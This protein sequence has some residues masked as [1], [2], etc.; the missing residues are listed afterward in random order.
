MVLLNFVLVWKNKKIEKK[1]IVLGKKIMNL[2][3]AENKSSVKSLTKKY[4][5][6]I[7]SINDKDYFLIY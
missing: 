5:V 7:F 6:Y 4:Q 2:V 3:L 1:R